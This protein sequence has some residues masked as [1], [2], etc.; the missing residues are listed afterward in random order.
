MG[1]DDFQHSFLL[2]LVI[3]GTKNSTQQ[4]DVRLPISITMLHDMI[5][6]L[7]LVHPNHFEVCM[8]SA[9][10][11]V[12]FHG[13]FRPGELTYSQHSITVDNVHILANRTVIILLTSKANN[14]HTAQK[15]VIDKHASQCCP[16]DLLTKF[17]HLR[18]RTIGPL[19]IKLD[20]SPVFSKDVANL[21]KHVSFVP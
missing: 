4:P 18:P 16:V 15:V 9:L 5:D 1:K 13:L 11:A 12:G 6:T 21:V 14:T 2:K 17:L 10:S 19:F 3:C 20:S 8:Y 7:Q